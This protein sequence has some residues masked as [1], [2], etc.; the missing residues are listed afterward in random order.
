MIDLY[1]TL[2]VEIP[3]LKDMMA[4]YNAEDM[5]TWIASYTTD[6]KKDENAAIVEATCDA[7]IKLLLSITPFKAREYV[8]KNCAKVKHKIMSTVK[9]KN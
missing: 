9:E 6:L 3:A 2:K 7:F 8:E 4:V 1:D 5:K